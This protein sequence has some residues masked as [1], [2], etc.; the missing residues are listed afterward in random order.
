M[1]RVYRKTQLGA[2][3]SLSGISFDPVEASAILAKAV[4]KKLKPQILGL[5]KSA[6]NT[7]INELKPKL[8]EIMK[9]A[10]PAAVNELKPRIP[11]LVD[12]AIPQIP[13]II[14]AAEPP[15]E[16]YIQER[17]YPNTLRPLIVKELQTVGKVTG[18]KTS[19]AA[20]G[21][22]SILA[23]S[24]LAYLVLSKKKERKDR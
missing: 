22:G 4:M 5:V 6:T 7:A 15:L 21:V 16:K 3:D 1:Y 18:E 2:Y 13:K 8:P 23:V 10:I 24:V 14:K 19:R 11:E 9:E 20:V 17:L 12:S